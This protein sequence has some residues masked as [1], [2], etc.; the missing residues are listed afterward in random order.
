MMCKFTDEEGATPPAKKTKSK[1]TKYVRKVDRVLNEALRCKDAAENVAGPG[2]SVQPT[3]QQVIQPVILVVPSDN[4]AATVEAIKSAFRG[5]SEIPVQTLPYETAHPSTEKNTVAVGMDHP[6]CYDFSGQFNSLAPPFYYSSSTG[7][8]ANASCS[9]DQQLV[10]FAPNTTIC[11]ETQQATTVG[12]QYDYEA[13]VLRQDRVRDRATSTNGHYMDDVFA[14]GAGAEPAIDGPF[15]AMVTSKVLE[16]NAACVRNAQTGMDAS[17]FDLLRDIETQTTWN[18]VGLMTDFW[19]D[20]GNK[21]V[22]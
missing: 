4:I 17:E 6:S 10:E 9:T 11:Y 18:D 7:E 5:T 12:F 2:P 8:T 21:L 19:T 15:S 3:S 20:M 16:C 14:G 22:D 13:E 1:K